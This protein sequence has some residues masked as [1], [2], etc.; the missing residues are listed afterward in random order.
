MTLFV[1]GFDKNTDKEDLETLFRKCGELLDV[2][3]LA[4]YAFIEMLH[5]GDAEYAIKRLNGRWWNGRRL[6]VTQKR[7]RRSNWDDWDEED[8]ELF[9][10]ND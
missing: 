5:E 1:A 4:G 10:K 2:K 9:R 8:E 7:E 6:K 3:I